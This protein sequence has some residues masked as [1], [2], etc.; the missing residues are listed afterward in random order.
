M[1]F[2]G[3]IRRSIYTFR[4]CHFCSNRSG[5]SHWSLNDAYYFLRISTGFE[6]HTVLRS[7]GCLYLYKVCAKLPFQCFHLSTDGV[8]LIV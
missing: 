1:K 6:R 2:L 5:L 4:Y 3:G 7:F 8:N